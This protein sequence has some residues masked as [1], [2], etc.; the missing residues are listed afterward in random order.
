MRDIRKQCF[1]VL[2]HA[3]LRRRYIIDDN[4][5]LKC[6]ISM[7]LFKPVLQCCFDKDW[8]IFR[9]MAMS[10]KFHRLIIHKNR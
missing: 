7:I 9:T 10:V 2:R 8:L 1:H 3:Q 5:K 6:H 4:E